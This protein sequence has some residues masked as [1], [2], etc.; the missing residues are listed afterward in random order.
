ME[1]WP[2]RDAPRQG[3]SV[4]VR[5]A[6]ASRKDRAPPPKLVSPGGSAVCR[7]VPPCLRPSRLSGDWHSGLPPSRRSDPGSVCQM[8]ERYLRQNRPRPRRRR[9]PS[10]V[11]ADTKAGA[12][13]F[14]PFSRE[15]GGIAVIGVGEGVGRLSPVF[16]AKPL[17]T[18]ASGN[19]QGAPL[20]PSFI[21]SSSQCL[22]LGPRCE[23]SEPWKREPQGSPLMQGGAPTARTC[24]G[25]QGRGMGQALG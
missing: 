23:R 9:T 3:G 20:S 16:S 19:G 4:A 14:S 8:P 7:A 21:T 22:S 24:A 11:S 12:G 25:S 5:L 10:P 15:P 17:K 18:H 1:G 2:P 13:D 6:G